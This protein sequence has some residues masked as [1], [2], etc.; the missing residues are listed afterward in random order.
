MNGLR[1]WFVIVTGT[2]VAACAALTATRA[3]DFE[4]TRST[5]DGGGVMFSTGGSFELSG[6]IGQPDAG[7][8]LSTDGTFE[9]T[10]GFWFEEPPDDCNSDGCVDLI[11]YA[12][13]EGC[14]TG[15]GGELPLP[16]CICFD[17]D[18]D[19]DIDLSDIVEFQ[20]GFT[21]G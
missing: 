1:M 4:I 19:N 8:M 5:V 18:G 14:L 11:D 10:G 16:Q 12:D 7:V 3:D 15:P 9:L 6:T 13:F 2:V 17:I 21:G 20:S